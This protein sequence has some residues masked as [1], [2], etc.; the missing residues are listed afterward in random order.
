MREH[1]E[2]H[3][4]KQRARPAHQAIGGKG[5][6]KRAADGDVGLARSLGEFAVAAE[7]MKKSVESLKQELGKF[8]LED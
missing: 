6:Q 4:H 5:E 1:N 2:E 3:R 8:K 7:E